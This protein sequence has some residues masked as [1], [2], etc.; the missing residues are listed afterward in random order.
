MHHYF[1]ENEDIEALDEL[2]F[3]IYLT[4]DD[5]KHA[6]TQR[7]RVGEHIGIVDKVSNYFEV[8]ILEINKQ[9]LKVRITKKLNY[10]KPDYSLSLFYCLS[11]GTKTEDVLRAATEI[12]ID[13]FYPIESSRSI[14]K[15][16][17]NKATSRIERFERV[18]KSASMQAG[19]LTIPRIHNVH[20][21]S[22]INDN[23]SLLDVLIV[24]WEE[25]SPDDA[26]YKALQGRHNRIGILVGPEGGLDETEIEFLR[27]VSNAKICT[28]GDTILRTETAG[29]IACALIKYELERQDD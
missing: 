16:D 17:A 5:L 23:L 20:Q 19:R 24:F 9:G 1:I 18:A 28:M 25:A 3:E 29:S 8:E 2:E 4:A 6:K 15:L 10:K 7:L 12:G 26:L 11:K 22:D 14:V 27:S 21:L 13:E